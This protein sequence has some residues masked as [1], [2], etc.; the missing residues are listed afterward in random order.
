MALDVKIQ[1]QYGYLYA[2]FLRHTKSWCNKSLIYSS[3]LF[4]FFV[5]KLR[6]QSSSLVE[7]LSEDSRPEG[8]GF[9]PPQGISFLQ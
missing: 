3:T 1:H 7:R 9:D 4:Q 5:L 6:Y 8:P 2:P